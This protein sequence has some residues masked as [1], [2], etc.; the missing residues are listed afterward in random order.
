MKT[1]D[2]FLIG[3][4]I[5]CFIINPLL[6]CLVIASIVLFFLCVYFAWKAETEKMVKDMERRQ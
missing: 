2:I 5:A 3:L 4:G 6:G 1:I